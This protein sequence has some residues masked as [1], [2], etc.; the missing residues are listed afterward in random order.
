MADITKLWIADKMREIMKRKPLS[1]I[2]VTENCEAAG[3]E[4]PTFY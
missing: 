3:I 4:R 2:R 1:K